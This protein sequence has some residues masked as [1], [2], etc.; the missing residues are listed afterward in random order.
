[1]LERNPTAIEALVP[2]LHRCSDFDYHDGDDDC[3]HCP[4]RRYTRGTSVFR[5]LR[6]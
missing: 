3:T 2:E 5:F 6:K 1:M 4:N